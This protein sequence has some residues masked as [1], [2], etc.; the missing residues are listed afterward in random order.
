MTV[1]RAALRA[2]SFSQEGRYGAS[3]AIQFLITT[4]QPCSM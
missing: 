4:G 1:K 2:T 3:Q